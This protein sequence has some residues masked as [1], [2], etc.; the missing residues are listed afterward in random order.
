MFKGVKELSAK[1]ASLFPRLCKLAIRS[2]N[3]TLLVPV[4]TR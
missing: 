1:E 3:A 2:K 4:A